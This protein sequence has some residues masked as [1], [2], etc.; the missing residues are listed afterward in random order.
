MF[1]KFQK[2]RKFK[3]CLHVINVAQIPLF[4]AI[5]LQ[6]ECDLLGGWLKVLYILKNA[7]KGAR[8][9]G[10]PQEKQ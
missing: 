9:Y 1:N 10:H 2:K 7:S 8:T 6:I 5:F 4:S 3:I